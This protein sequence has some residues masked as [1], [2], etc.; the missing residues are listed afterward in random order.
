[1]KINLTC[2]K[3]C[4]I[5]TVYSGKGWWFSVDTLTPN[6]EMF[7]TMSQVCTYKHV[8]Y[9]LTKQQGMDSVVYHISVEDIELWVKLSDYLSWDGAIHW[10]LYILVTVRAWNSSSY[11][12]CSYGSI[13]FCRHWSKSIHIKQPKSSFE[14]YPY[15]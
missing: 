13:L 15:M 11:L 9:S 7:F 3:I 2:A 5:D 14:S 10:I 8:Q 6:M 4:K 1:M 12:R